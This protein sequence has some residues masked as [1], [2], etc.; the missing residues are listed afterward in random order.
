VQHIFV[1][2]FVVVAAVGVGAASRAEAADHVAHV[3]CL[4]PAAR[5]LLDMAIERSLAIRSFVERLER[6]DVVVYLQLPGSSEAAD[7]VSHLTFVSFVAGTRYLL[8]QID[9]WRTVPVGRIAMLGHE[10]YHAIEIAQEPSVCDTRTLRALYR[11]IG[12]EYGH[13]R[14][15]TEPAR[16]AGHRVRAELDRPR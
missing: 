1:I 6:S 10:L 9:P 15:E 2:A 13:G 8:V 16:M 14:F 11:R 3:R 5:E 4:D 12:H 7:S